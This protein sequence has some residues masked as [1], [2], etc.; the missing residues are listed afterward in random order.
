MAHGVHAAALGVPEG[1]GRVPAKEAVARLLGDH[2][3]AQATA[4]ATA[5]GRSG[6]RL[7]AGASGDWPTHVVPAFVW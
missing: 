1:G 7:D 6:G 5:V 4:Q 3:A 2:A